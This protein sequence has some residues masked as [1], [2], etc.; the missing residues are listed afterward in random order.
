MRRQHCTAN[1]RRKRH[2]NGMRTDRIG[3]VDLGDEAQVADATGWWETLTG[4]GG[5]G[6]VV[7]PADFVP[8]VPRGLWQPAL[9]C[10][11]REYLRIIYGPDYTAPENLDR[12]RRRGLGRKRSLAQREFVLGLTALD[13]FVRREPLR[14][15][16]ECVFGILALESEP[17]DPRL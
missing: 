14:L 10:R 7:K 4:N 1:A 17:V 12:L 2:N 11:G 5:E 3:A 8:Q 13:R 15:V 16:H 9:R 6:M